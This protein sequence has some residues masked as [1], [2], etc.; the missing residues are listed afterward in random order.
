MRKKIMRLF[1]K[2]Y[3][4]FL[5]LVV[6]AFSFLGESYH[7][8]VL[9]NL[10]G[11]NIRLN[12]PGA[13]EG[14]NP[15]GSRFVISEMTSD[16]IL[17]AAKAGLKLEKYTNDQLRKRLFITTKFS[18]AAMDEVVSDIRDGMHGSYVPTTF[19]VYYSQKNKLAKNE[20]HEFLEALAEN[21][22]DYFYKNHAENNSILRF[23][24]EEDAFVNYDYSEIYAV[25]YEKADQMLNYMKTH[26]EENRGYRSSDQINFSALIDELTNFKDV[27]LEKFYAY[28]IQNNITK[29]RGT[30]INK[31]SYL[32][33]YHNQSYRKKSS[34]SEITK[35][36]LYQYDPQI[37]AVAFVPSVDSANNYYMSRTK[38]G[39]DDLA[40]NSYS[41]GM[42]AAR[43]AQKIDDYNNRFSKMLAASDTEAETIAKAEEY[44]QGILNDLKELS[45][46]ILQLD[47]E[48]LSYKTNDYFTYVVDPKSSLLNLSITIKFAIFGLILALLMIL[49]LEFFHQT[50]TE[51]TRR[52]KRI[53]DVM[54]EIGKRGRKR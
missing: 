50:V 24:P 17:D 46:K 52:Y 39:I 15:D 34:A 21:Y 44:L 49:Y 9:S 29:N 12:Y 13:E 40:K 51:K 41:D 25:L 28:M 32:L 35:A 43:V 31:L 53:L 20:T 14:L 11:M 2:K 38:T 54:T 1:Q 22:K 19:H 4:A 45:D 8:L 42:E 6:I 37:I 47:G 26:R 10:K 27:K 33:D 5:L 7:V 16:E 3:F 18:Q 36:A 30:Y 23:E 48:Y